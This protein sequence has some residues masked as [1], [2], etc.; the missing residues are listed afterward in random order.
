MS[1]GGTQLLDSS[2]Q[3]QIMWHGLASAGP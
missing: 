2:S 3:L 1:S